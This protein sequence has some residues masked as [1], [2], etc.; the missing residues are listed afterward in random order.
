MEQIQIE[1]IYLTPTASG[2]MESKQEVKLLQ[3]LG[4]EGDRYASKKGTYSVLRASKLSP[5]EPE[6]GRHLTL[7]SAQGVRESLEAHGVAWPTNKPL[8]DLRR[9]ILLKNISSSQLLDLVGS[10]LQIG[11]EAKLFVHRNCVPCMYNERKNQVPGLM[12]ALWESGGVSCQV[13]Q[14]G[15]VQ[16]GDTIQVLQPG[17]NDGVQVD[18]GIQSSGFFVRPSK[19]SAAMVKE[20]LELQKKN[21]ALLLEQ[22]PEGVARAQKSYESVGL[23]FWPKLPNK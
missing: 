16:V 20:A 12:E 11:D 14:G 10:T 1:E 3:G 23:K 15:R 6:P 18:E 8:G 13:I 19:R 21:L 2:S 4:I 22:D 9:N 7:I 17:E 5:G